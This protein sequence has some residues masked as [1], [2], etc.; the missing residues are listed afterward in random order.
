MEMK[1][2]EKKI[3]NESFHSF[4]SISDEED[5]SNNLKTQIL[6]MKKKE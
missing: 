1:K 2:K 3:S 5:N 4:K 6:K